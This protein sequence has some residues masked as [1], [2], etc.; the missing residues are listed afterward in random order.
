MK[1]LQ[2]N[3]AFYPAFAYGGTVNVSYNLS[4][5]LAKRGHD[6]NLSAINPNQ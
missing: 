5:A 1:I 2:L 4:K 3:P 6:A